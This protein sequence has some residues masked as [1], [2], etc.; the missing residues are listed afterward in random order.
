MVGVVGGG[1][2]TD[3]FLK[4]ERLKVHMFFWGAPWTCKDSFG[5]KKR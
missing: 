3:E 2:L 5:L 4:D 1:F